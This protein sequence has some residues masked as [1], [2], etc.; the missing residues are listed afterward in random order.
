M[1]GQ[2]ERRE[3]TSGIDPAPRQELGQGF[4]IRQGLVAWAQVPEA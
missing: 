4:Q 3:C 1:A 2:V